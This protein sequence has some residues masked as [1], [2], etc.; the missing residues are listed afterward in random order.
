M[1][2]RIADIAVRDPE[3]TLELVVEVKSRSGRSE[4]WAARTLRNLLV[5]GALPRAPYFL[6]VLPDAMYLW[7]DRDGKLFSDPRLQDGG[8]PPDYRA[9][10]SAA[11]SPYLDGMPFALE[12][13][14]GRS[15]E[16][17]VA[18]WLTGVM[19]SEV[20]EEPGLRW[21]LDSGLYEAIRGGRIVTEVVV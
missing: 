18:S 12:E 16:M 6:L 10:T 1:E 8:R 2:H 3:G 21:L 14:G 11:L 17:V 4:G 7:D 13:L 5:H 20:R 9:D 15:L 19:N